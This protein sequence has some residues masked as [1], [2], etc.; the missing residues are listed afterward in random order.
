MADTYEIRPKRDFGRYE[1]LIDGKMVKEGFVVTDGGNC[2]VMPGATWFLTE[3]DAQ[4][5]LDLWLSVGKDAD[6][7]WTAHHAAHPPKDI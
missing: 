5:S 7:F 2:N 1:W 3:A 6:A 4:E